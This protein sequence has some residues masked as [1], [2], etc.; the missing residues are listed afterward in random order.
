MKTPG[1]ALGPLILPRERYGQ[2]LSANNILGMVSLALTPSLIGWLLPRIG[3][4]RYVFIFCGVVTLLALAALLALL[5]QWKKLCGDLR[6]TP[7]D[8]LLKKSHA[9]TP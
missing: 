1:L 7:P 2:F 3:D 4:Y 8:P 9:S 5:A 6:F